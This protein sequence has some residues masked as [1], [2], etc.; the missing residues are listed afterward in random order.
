[1]NGYKQK[2]GDVVIML[3]HERYSAII[4]DQIIKCGS[5]V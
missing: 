5:S 3:T 4:F 2:N 1:M